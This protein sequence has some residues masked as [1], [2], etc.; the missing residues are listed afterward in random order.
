M[1]GTSAVFGP[2]RPNEEAAKLPQPS[3]VVIDAAAEALLGPQYV[4]RA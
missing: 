3:M 1:L 2:L 4:R